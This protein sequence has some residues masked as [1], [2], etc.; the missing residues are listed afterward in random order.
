MQDDT[1]SQSDVV[2]RSHLFTVQIW[3]EHLG[4]DESEWRGKVEYVP[5]REAR[6]FR[7]WSMLID[8]LLEVL[9]RQDLQAETGGKSIQNEEK[10][11]R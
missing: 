3:R 10:C 6:Y 7:E 11:K 5:S 2:Y 1:F 9:S 8:F 4:G